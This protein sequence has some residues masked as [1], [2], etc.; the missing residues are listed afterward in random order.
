MLATIELDR[1]SQLVAVEVEDETAV[2]GFDRMLATELG[3]GEAPIAQ[4]RPEKALGVALVQAQLASEGEEVV[5]ERC[6]RVEGRFAARTRRAF[7]R[8]AVLALSAR[9]R[10]GVREGIRRPLS[11]AFCCPCSLT[12]GPSP[13]GRGEGGFQVFAIG[14]DQRDHLL[15][16]DAGHEVQ[17]G[18]DAMVGGQRLVRGCPVAHRRVVEEPLH[19]LRQR[20]QDRAQDDGQEAEVVDELGAGF[21]QPVALRGILRHGP[22][23][24]AVDVAIDLVRDVHDVPQRL[25]E[26]APLVMPGD[27][28]QHFIPGRQVDEPLPRLDLCQPPL[29]ALDQELR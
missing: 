13:G 27:R 28:I 29:E 1:Q 15:R 9:E 6:M 7:G 23:R 16:V 11:C 25:A 20:R 21:V 10:V 19:L 14:V 24:E 26:I 17:V 12:P 5:W 4:Q 18:V 2:F 8:G 3:T 22:G